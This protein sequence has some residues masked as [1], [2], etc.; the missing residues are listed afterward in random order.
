MSSQWL[1][2]SLYS[3]FTY[4]YILKTLQLDTGCFFRR[5]STIFVILVLSFVVKHQEERQI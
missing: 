2:T 4:K 1:T 5:E 3:L